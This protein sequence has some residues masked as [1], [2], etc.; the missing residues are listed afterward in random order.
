MSRF[1]KMILNLLNLSILALIPTEETREEIYR[2]ALPALGLG[3]AKPPNHK[4]AKA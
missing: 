1:N 3:M 4:N 2:C